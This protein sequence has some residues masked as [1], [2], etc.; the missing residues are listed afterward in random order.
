MWILA[1][2]AVNLIT[3][4][5]GTEGVWERSAGAQSRGGGIY[6]SIEQG[7]L[8]RLYPQRGRLLTK[9]PG[10]ALN[11][12]TQTRRLKSSL[13]LRPLPAQDRTGYLL[14]IVGSWR[15]RL[16]LSSLLYE[17][18]LL[19]LHVFVSFEQELAELCDMVQV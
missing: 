12:S 2:S 7:Q 10:N 3:E 18:L 19:R 15:T 14:L 4:G 11:Q 8:L 5:G 9:Q 6:H 1:G 16:Y 17:Q 13:S